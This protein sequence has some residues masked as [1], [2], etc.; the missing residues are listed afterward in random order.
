M[1]LTISVFDNVTSEDYSSIRITIPDE[2]LTKFLESFEDYFLGARASKARPNLIP[3][4]TEL[5]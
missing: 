4:D 2:D 5:L 1:D 3:T